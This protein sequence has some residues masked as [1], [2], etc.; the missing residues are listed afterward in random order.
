[1][2]TVFFFFFFCFVLGF[3]FFFFFFVGS[4]YVKGFVGSYY[5]LQ[6]V[7]LMSILFV[8]SLVKWKRVYSGNVV[9]EISNFV[10][11]GVVWKEIDG[12][13]G[14]GWFSEYVSFEARWLLDYK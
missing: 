13:N 7:V 8:S 1:V 2:F 9:S 6:L 5:F 10:F 14:G 11:Y 4:A 3:F 12:C